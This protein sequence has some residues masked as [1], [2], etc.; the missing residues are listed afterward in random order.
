MFPGT[1]WPLHLPSPG[2]QETSS[3]H[4]LLG[5]EIVLGSSLEEAQEAPRIKMVPEQVV[6]P[7]S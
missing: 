7:Y 5:T 3:S 6:V 2:S 4:Q 1:Q